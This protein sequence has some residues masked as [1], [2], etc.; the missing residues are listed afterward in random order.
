MDLQ[1]IIDVLSWDQVTIAII[2]YFAGFMTVV[3]G[4]QNR[5]KK[6]MKELQVK[7]T[8]AKVRIEKK[9]KEYQGEG[10]TDEDLLNDILNSFD[11]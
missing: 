4:Y 11:E 3:V 1:K 7:E 9:I 6:V 8:A 2:A 10:K 5:R